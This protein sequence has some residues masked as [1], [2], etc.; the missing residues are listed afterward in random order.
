MKN[1]SQAEKRIL[2]F[3]AFLPLALALAFAAF[4]FFRAESIK[5]AAPGPL[6]KEEASHLQENLG[7]IYPKQILRP[8]PYSLLPPEFDTNARS[9][10]L[11]NANTG[12]ILFEKNADAQIPPASM[13]KLF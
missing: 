13:T 3:S 10:I 1:H 2:I 4:L 9:A 8:L 5:N 11:I 7:E 6:P 12:E